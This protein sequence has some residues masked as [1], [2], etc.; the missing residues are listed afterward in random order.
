MGRR[1]VQS[2]A[3]PA[4]PDATAER[5]RDVNT[6]YHDLAAGSYD[7]KWGIDFGEI[8]RRQVAD[9]AP[10]GARRRARAL[11]A[12]A[13]DRRR[14]RLLLAEPDARRHDRAAPPPPT[15]HPACSPRCARTPSGSA[16]TS[17]RSQ[18]D[19]EDLPFPDES[20]DLVLGHAVLHHIPDLDRAA[21]EF[22]RVLRPGGTVVFCGEPSANG[23]R[24]AA[25]PEARRRARRPRVA[26][27]RRRL[28]ARRRRRLR[29]RL[30]PRPRGGG[31]RPRLRPRNARA[32]PSR[33]PASTDARVRG[34]ELLA[35]MYGWVLRTR[36]VH[37]RAGR[38]PQ[39]LAPL[40]LQLL[41]GPAAGRHGRCWSRACPRSSSTT[42]SSRR[43]SRRPRPAER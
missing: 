30:R 39:P 12:S 36:R 6:R 41:P 13:R 35:N 3:M 8:G 33:P 19:A 21:A 11:R 10:Q 31:R 5:I 29:P 37:R 24:L 23:D 20:F 27:R 22:M 25:W 28:R 15:S 18:A 17:T 42:S 1:T 38:D 4:A 43:A 9:E 7:A 40:R 26:P 14:D 32:A 2:A 34:E 16:S